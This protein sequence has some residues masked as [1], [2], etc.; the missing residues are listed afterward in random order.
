MTVFDRHV[1]D[2]RGESGRRAKSRVQT[3]VLMR[4][5]VLLAVALVCFVAGASENRINNSNTIAG[6]CTSEERDRRE[7]GRLA[8]ANATY[9]LFAL[10]QFEAR[11]PDL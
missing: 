7:V 6:G 3:W 4:S 11:S 5:C 9:A 8:A 10:S 2:R 1:C